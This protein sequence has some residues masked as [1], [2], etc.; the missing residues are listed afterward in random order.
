[1]GRLALI[2]NESLL[3]GYVSEEWRGAEAV[4]ILKMCKN[5]Y[6]SSRSFQPISLASSPFKGME[7][8]IGG[9]DWGH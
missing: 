2:Y 7:K 1:M 5:D 9:G 8:V 4:L 3:L 6:S